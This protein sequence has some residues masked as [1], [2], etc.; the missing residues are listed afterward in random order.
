MLEVKN[1]IKK[2][3]KTTAVN[4]M[5]FT[6]KDGE[7]GVLLGPNGAG[8]STIIKSTAGLLTHD[9]EVKVNGK[10]TGTLEAKKEFAYIP[11]LPSLY[12]DLT[13]REHL[14]FIAKAYK[15]PDTYRQEAEELLEAFE[16]TDKADRLG[17]ELSK[18][19]MQKTSICMA[20]I[21][22]PSCILVDEPMVGLDPKAIRK[23]KSIL[24][25]L[26]DEGVSILISTHMLEMI[27]DMWDVMVVIKEGK[28][29]GTFHKEDLKDETISRFFFEITE[30]GEGGE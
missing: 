6:I 14:D 15:L 21:T 19:M 25:K 7:I 28:V 24:C 3:P 22:K 23:L 8:K 30:Q 27:D 4:D 16:M 17:T 2:Y 13:V 11:E 1:L 20:L 10:D 5:S 12:D 18:G 9:G 26:R 29:L